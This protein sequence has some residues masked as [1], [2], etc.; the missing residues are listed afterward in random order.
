HAGGSDLG[1]RVRPLQGPVRARR[2]RRSLARPVAAK[3]LALA[4]R[5]GR[6]K[7]RTDPI[8]PIIGFAGMTHLGV[9]SAAGALARGF[10]VV[11]YDAD[12]G[13][14]EKLKRG[15]PPVLEPG[16]AETLQRHAG[17]A[18]LT[19]QVSDLRR[20][21]LVYIAADVPTD[22]NG[23]SDLAPIRSLI[24]QVSGALS[25]KAVLVILCQ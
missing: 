5:A 22:D 20:C 23:A 4:R 15:E 21:D 18:S 3:A 7:I 10:Q 6:Q 12:T 9:N 2:R 8:S 19:S 24:T 14:I 17:K 13:V 11:G 25:S 16:L 1:A